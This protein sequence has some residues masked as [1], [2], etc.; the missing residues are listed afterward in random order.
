M[1]FIEIESSEYDDG[2]PVPDECY[3]LFCDEQI[4][5]NTPFGYFCQKCHDEAAG[6]EKTKYEG[7]LP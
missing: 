5:P 6:N 4:N 3:C 7:I 1:K 2:L